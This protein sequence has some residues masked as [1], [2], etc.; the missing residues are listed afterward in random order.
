M[1][2]TGVCPGDAASGRAGRRPGRRITSRSPRSS[3]IDGV[4][5]SRY[6]VVEWGYPDIG[7]VLC[8]TPS[9]GHDTVML[10]YRASGPLGEPRVAYVDED[11]SDVVIAETFSDFIANL[12]DCPQFRTAP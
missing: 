12:I 1:S 3:G 4:Y 7:L 5:G 8:E 2:R 6:L 9:G 11:R 10:D